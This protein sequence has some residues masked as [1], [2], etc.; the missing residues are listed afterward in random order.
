[1]LCDDTGPYQ[2]MGASFSYGVI[3]NSIICSNQVETFVLRPKAPFQIDIID[4]IV[5]LHLPY[6]DKMFQHYE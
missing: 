4:K 6:F 1:M 3:E 5:F 2:R